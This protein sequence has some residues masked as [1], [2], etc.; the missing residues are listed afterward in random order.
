MSKLVIAS[1]SI[2]LKVVRKKIVSNIKWLEAQIAVLNVNSA[3]GKRMLGFYSEKIE[4]QKITL[5]WL[6]KYQ[7]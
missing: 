6:N 5:E 4:K 1:E 2:E 3:L 7:N